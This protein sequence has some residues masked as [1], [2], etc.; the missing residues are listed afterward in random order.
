LTGSVPGCGE[1]TANETFK[2]V[3]PAALI[4]VRGRQNAKSAKSPIA[5]ISQ[6]VP[7]GADAYLLI[8]SLLRRPSALR[9][10]GEVNGRWPDPS[11]TV[12]GPEVTV[13]SHFP[14]NLEP[15]GGPLAG[16][17]S[18]GQI[19]SDRRCD[20]RKT[21]VVLTH[22]CD[23]TPTAR[24]NGLRQPIFHTHSVDRSSNPAFGSGDD[25]CDS[26]LLAPRGSSRNYS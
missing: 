20:L 13:S 11:W 9:Q 7:T 17:S 22:G 2:E 10:A 15:L 21:G 4:S 18:K 8:T 19:L 26:A 3:V 5:L 6:F 25:S 1:V 23:A 14:L 16:R 24:R 12:L